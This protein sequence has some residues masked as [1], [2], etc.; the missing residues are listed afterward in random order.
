MLF[1]LLFCFKN[2]AEEGDEEG[3]G[4]APAPADSDEETEAMLND[5]KLGTKVRTH[6]DKMIFNMLLLFVIE[7]LYY[8]DILVHF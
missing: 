4:D 6:I 5:P 3:D 7:Y 1:C 8:V 2:T